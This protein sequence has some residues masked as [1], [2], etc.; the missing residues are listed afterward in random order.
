MD[1]EKTGPESDKPDS[2]P[3]KPAEPSAEKDK[4]AGE[5]PRPGGSGKRS[6]KPDEAG[7][8]PSL[9]P[10]NRRKLRLGIV[11]VA[12]VV[13]VVAW[14]ASRDGGDGSSEPETVEPGPPRIV[15]AAELQE[16]SADL[17]QT[18]YWAGPM[19]GTE[20]E[21]NELGEGGV[22]V[23]YLPEGTEAGEG[24]RKALT[25]GTYTLADPEAAIEAV[26][27][28]PGEV[29]RELPDGRPVV[30]S[31]SSPT[32]VY[33]ASPD[34]SVQVEVYAP[35]AKQAMSLALSSRVQPIG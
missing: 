9:T 2:G 31:E 6:A 11:A 5:G 16:A 7:A 3:A 15:T 4:P 20:L 14:V 23:R 13:A 34:N 17:G 27:K 30:T 29:V 12:I 19:E 32:N 24:S 18:I 28:R 35:S 25:V 26:S 33:F 1:E 8:K 10:E 22:Q 21:L